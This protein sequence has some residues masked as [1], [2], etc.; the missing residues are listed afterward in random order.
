MNPPSPAPLDSGC[1]QAGAHD[2]DAWLFRRYPPG[3]HPL[4]DLMLQIRNSPGPGPGPGQPLAGEPADSRPPR[5]PVQGAAAVPAAPG[6]PLDDA[7]VARRIHELPPLPQALAEALR[8]VRRD[9]LSTATCVRAIEQDAVLAAAVLRLANSPFYGAC[10]RVSSV[11][12]AVR[13]LGLR[14]VSGVVVAVSMRRTLAQWRDDDGRFQAYWRHAV[15]TATAARELAPT[16]GADPDEAFLTGL[17][18][19]LGRLVMAVFSP[20]QARLALARARADDIDL[21]EAETQLL[22]R[23]H[24]DVGAAVARHWQLPD[25]I[26]SAIALHHAPGAASAP[27]VIP[28][29]ALIHVADAITHALDLVGDPAEAVPLVSDHAWCS[30]A[31]SHGVMQRVFERVKSGVALLAPEP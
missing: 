19:D 30:I 11:G 31:P 18:H 10:G 15:A 5:T 14:T 9:D 16:A 24:D 2:R 3:P 23:R 8:V 26:V 21:R 27:G 7:E 25:A 6:E 4:R 1:E 22:G 12:D 20:G 13:L 17:L 29:E 28:L